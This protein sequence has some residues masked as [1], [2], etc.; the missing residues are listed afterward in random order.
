MTFRTWAA[1]A[2]CA[3]GV[4]G[5]A[6]A[7]F[8]GVVT[9]EYRAQGR[10]APVKVVQYVKDGRVRAEPQLPE[11]KGAYA[12]IDGPKQR[13]TSVTPARASYFVADLKPVTVL[14]KFTRTGKQAT[15][16][17]HACEHYTFVTAATPDAVA[18]MCIAKGLGYSGA[19]LG[20]GTEGAGDLPDLLTLSKLPGDAEWQALM[21]GG[22]F[23]LSVTRTQQGAVTFQSRVLALQPKKLAAGLFVPPEDY[24]G[25]TLADLNR[26]M[27]STE[28]P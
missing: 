23:A 13:L 26:M 2:A 11:A 14:P 6:V 18:D 9:Y 25:T 7:Q 12:I 4:P 24:R 3:A 8:E 5:L 17:G 22:A 21:K 20:R 28:A 1:L 15:I 10:P 19:T 16:A 27:K